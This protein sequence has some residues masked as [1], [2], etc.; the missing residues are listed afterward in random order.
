MQSLKICS[1][2]DKK[3]ICLLK[4]NNMRDHCESF[5]QNLQTFPSKKHFH[6][7]E[8]NCSLLVDVAA[9]YASARI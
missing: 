3:S 1:L 4:C 9:F 7:G 2:Y 5:S 6:K 8:R